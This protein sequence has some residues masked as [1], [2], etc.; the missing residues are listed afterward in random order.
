[1]RHPLGTLA[2]ASIAPLVLAA[3]MV[4]NVL[5]GFAADTSPDRLS[6]EMLATSSGLVTAGGL[7]TVAAAWAWLGAPSRTR[8]RFGVGYTVAIALG[9]AVFS[10]MRT[11]GA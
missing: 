3:S 7:G 9:F 4:L 5:L 8:A 11:Y 2:L 6:P 10:F 1:M